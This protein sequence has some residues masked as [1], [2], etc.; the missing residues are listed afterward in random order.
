MQKSFY[1]K[2]KKKMTEITCEFILVLVITFLINLPFGY[3]RGGV[4]KFSWQW[5]VAIH[6]PVVLLYFTRSWL[7]V[8]RSWV[9]LPIMVVFF[10][11][12]QLV[13]KKIRQRQLKKEQ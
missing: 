9:T 2:I 10:F 7:G 11:L 1:N 8:E 5:F 12:G 3:W 4:K 13:G 6:F